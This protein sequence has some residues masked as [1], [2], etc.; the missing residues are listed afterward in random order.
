[1]SNS[2]NIEGYQQVDTYENDKQYWVYYALDKAEYAK[3]KEQKKQS[4]ITK[5]TNLISSAYSDEQ[6]LDF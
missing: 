3:Q 5:A 2:E 4:T 1:M 6:N